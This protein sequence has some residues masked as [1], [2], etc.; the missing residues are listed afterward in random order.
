[1]TQLYEIRQRER[2]FGRRLQLSNIKF[3]CGMTSGYTACV[4]SAVGNLVPVRYVLVPVK[5]LLSRSNNV[6]MIS[7]FSD[8]PDLLIR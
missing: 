4:G 2:W 7:G 8:L 3:G 5:L 6:F 1:M